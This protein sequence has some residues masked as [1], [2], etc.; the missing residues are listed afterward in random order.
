LQHIPRNLSHRID[1]ILCFPKTHRQDLFVLMSSRNQTSVQNFLRRPERKL[2][3]A[4]LARA[5]F[6]D[7][8]HEK[9]KIFNSLV[10]GA[11]R[12]RKTAKEEDRER[13]HYSY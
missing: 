5:K 11:K 4:N 9:A 6:P 1:N 8:T 12:R 7:F 2:S 13:E 3:L 10:K